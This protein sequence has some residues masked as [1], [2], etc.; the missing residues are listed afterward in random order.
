MRRG[1]WLKKERRTYPEPLQ[2]RKAST[3]LLPL[4]RDLEVR[5]IE[6]D[7]AQVKGIKAVE[8]KQ[9]GEKNSTH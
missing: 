3:A 6:V 5:E 4:G 1:V 2:S 9:N 7:V 8:G